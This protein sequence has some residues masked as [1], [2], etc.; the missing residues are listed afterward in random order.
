MFHGHDKPSKS[1]LNLN[2]YAL[3]VSA[4]ALQLRRDVQHSNSFCSV[5]I[6]CTLLMS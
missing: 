3:A 2:F 5:L 4:D 6:L 1:E